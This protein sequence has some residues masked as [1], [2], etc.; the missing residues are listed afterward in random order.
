MSPSLRRAPSP[1]PLL[2]LTVILC[3]VVGQAVI[4]QEPPP[5]PPDAPPAAPPP[6]PDPPVQTQPAPPEALPTEMGPESASSVETVPVEPP[7]APPPPRPRKPRTLRE[8]HDL[9]VKRM[10]A[11]APK[12]IYLLI[13][14]GTNR[15]YLMRE[16][17]ILRE[18]V[19]S[20]GSGR[21]LPDPPRN[22][23]WTFDTPK[24]EFRIQRKFVEPVWIKPDWAFIEE[25]EPLPK[26][27]QERVAPEE[28][29]EYA[30]DLGDGYL[31]HGTLYERSLGLSVTHGCVRLGA[32][33]LDA[34][35]HTV[36][37]GTPVY[38]F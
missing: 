22:R 3:L 35:F 1:V 11:L 26:R 20:T 30:M 2:L 4:S 10:A 9:L 18:A 13:D 31:I 32:K 38:I 6:E 14:T 19:C 33:D 17:C 27:L 12:R 28:M 23:E 25:G 7:P 5:D 37:I 36:R 8:K 34:I 16:N 21:F 24:G 29:G 15:L